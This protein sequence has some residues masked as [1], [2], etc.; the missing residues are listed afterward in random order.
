MT[1]HTISIAHDLDTPEQWDRAEDD[2]AMA[3]AGGVPVVHP[4]FVH[5]TQYMKLKD[6]LLKLR[7]ENHDLRKRLEGLDE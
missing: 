1:K 6:E 7:K 4:D 5:V 2:M 3:L